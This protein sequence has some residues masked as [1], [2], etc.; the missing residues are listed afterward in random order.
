MQIFYS[1]SELQKQI[2]NSYEVSILRLS[3]DSTQSK[4]HAARGSEHYIRCQSLVVCKH[5][6]ILLI[7]NRHKNKPW[8]SEFQ[9]CK[10]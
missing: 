9:G 6:L 3:A 4:S 1:I 2:F 10:I 5:C 8:V 7:P